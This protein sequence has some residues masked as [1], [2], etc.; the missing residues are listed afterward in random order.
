MAKSKKPDNQLLEA[1][2]F[3]SLVQTKGLSDIASHCRL[4]P[5]AVIASNGVVSAGIST[6]LDVEACPHTD[7]LRLTL[8]SSSRQCAIVLMDSRLIIRSGDFQGFVP[9]CESS[10]LPQVNPDAVVTEIS[11]KLTHALALAL[12]VASEKA[13]Y[14]L[15]AAIQV[16]DG[17]VL[18]TDNSVLIEAWHGHDLPTMLIPRPAAAAIVK[19]KRKLTGFGYSGDTATF[20]F[21]NNAWIKTMLFKDAIPDVTKHINQQVDLNDVPVGYF[22]AIKLVAPFSGDGRILISGSFVSSH[23]DFN[24][25]GKVERL[26]VELPA[27]IYNHKQLKIVSA[28]AKTMDITSHDR[29]SFYYGEGVRAV[30]AHSEPIAK[31]QPC[32]VRQPITDDDIPF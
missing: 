16:R 19:C 23:V 12:P 9:C 18:A 4:M 15:N 31:Q 2:K 29:C 7:T 20:W 24:V 25:G 6:D 14:L 8:E 5:Y 10:K 17:A 28:F 11:E 22:E 13:T 3:V 26:E 30:I 32:I 21:G 1:I 27:R